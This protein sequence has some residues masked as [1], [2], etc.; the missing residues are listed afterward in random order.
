MRIFK[1]II[2]N[3]GF[4]KLELLRAE[5]DWYYSHFLVNWLIENVGIVAGDRLMTNDDRKNG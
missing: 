2:M 1:G 3:F 4:I 5:R